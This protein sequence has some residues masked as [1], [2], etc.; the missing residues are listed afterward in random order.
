[1]CLKAHFDKIIFLVKII[2]TAKLLNLCIKY[3]YNI[4]VKIKSIFALIVTDKYYL[5]TLM[6]IF[7]LGFM[8]CGKTSL[9]KRLARKIDYEFV[10]LDVLTE[11]IAGKKIED[12][13]INDGENAFRLVERDALLSLKD[14]QNLVVATGGGAPCFF[15]NMKTIIEMGISVYLRM[16]ATSL[17][18][19]L[20][21]SKHVRPLIMDKKGQD[22]IDKINELLNQREQFYLTANCIIKGENAKPEHIISLVFGQ[23]TSL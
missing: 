16:S 21:N 17:A 19:R 9:G 22:L 10:D 4:Q 14:K 23:E 5:I 15:D 8:G 20:E 1:L 11:E 13:I 12:I 6:R 2:Q 3:F 7:L 18:K